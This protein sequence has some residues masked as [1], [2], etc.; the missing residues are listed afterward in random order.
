M[1]PAYEA[2]NQ[3]SGQTQARADIHPRTKEYA[4]YILSEPSE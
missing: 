1:I 3:N 2:R 4:T